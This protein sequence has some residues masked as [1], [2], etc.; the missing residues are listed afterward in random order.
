MLR[1]TAGAK[2]V[3]ALSVAVK[4]VGVGYQNEVK[5][6]LTLLLSQNLYSQYKRGFWYDQLVMLETKYFNDYEKVSNCNYILHCYHKK[7]NWIEK[8]KNIEVMLQKRTIC[9]CNVNFYI[10]FNIK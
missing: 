10:N 5:D 4:H 3:S 9:T 8:N 6:W 2:Y 7:P 1:F